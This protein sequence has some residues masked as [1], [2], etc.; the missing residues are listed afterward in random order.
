M[1]NEL[2]IKITLNHN[3]VTY[4]K[5]IANTFF[6]NQYNLYLIHSMLLVQGYNV[7]PVSFDSTST[8]LPCALITL[9]V[10]SVLGL[11]PFTEASTPFE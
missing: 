3:I 11:T 7:T 9:S 5:F 2:N 6:Y 1:I 8:M 10:W 4:A